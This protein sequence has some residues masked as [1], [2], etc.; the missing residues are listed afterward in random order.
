[1]APCHTLLSFILT[2]I[3]TLVAASPKKKSTFI[4]QVYH[5][6]KPSIFPTH[7]HWYESSFTSIIN[8]ATA[9]ENTT[10]A[11]SAAILHTYDTVFHGFSTKL[12]PL[13][14]Q[15]LESLSH[16]VAVIPEQVRQLHTIRSLQFLG[17]KT[18][19][20]TGL[21]KEMDFGSDLIIGVIDTGICP[22]REFQ[23]PR[24]RPCS[25]QLEGQLHRWKGLPRRTRRVEESKSS[26]RLL[27]RAT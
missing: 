13:L 21:L 5:E 23:R 27:L 19:D 16:V 15:K 3:A 2:V 9:A 17:L 18:A 11:A 1:M 4:V 10:T 24:P 26:P 20:R 7:K 6:A 25:S 12:S 8:H 22:D 14:A